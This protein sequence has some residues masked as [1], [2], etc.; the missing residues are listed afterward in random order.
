M[1]I[2]GFVVFVGFAYLVY[3]HVKKTKAARTGGTGPGRDG[4]TDHEQSIK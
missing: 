2:L 1:E 4:N 3:R